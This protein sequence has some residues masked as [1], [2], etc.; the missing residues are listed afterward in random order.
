[1][2]VRTDERA[3]PAAA[4][5]APP[6]R[7][8]WW[9]AAW[10]LVG[11][12]ALAT[13]SSAD[14]LPFYDYYLWLFQGHVVGTLLFGAAGTP[15][16]GQA[17]ALSPVPVPNL[18]APVAIGL[19]NAWLPVETAGRVVVALTV[20]GFAAGFA[21]LARTVQG[22]PTWVEFAGVPWAFGFFLAKGY[23]SYLDGLALAFVVVALLHRATSRPDGPGAPTYGV[24]AVL[25]AALYL[26]HLLAW[27]IGV[28]AVVAHAVL[29][30]RRGRS[31]Q[32]RLLV[33]TQLPGAVMLGWY[34]AAERGG[35]GTAFYTSWT[36][37]AIALLE[38]AL[39]FLRLDPFPPPF[40]VFWANLAV[41]L[42][43]A[44][45]VVRQTR[46]AAA[47][48]ALAARPV[49]WLACALAAVALL[50]PI[51]ELND[52]IKPDER[53]VLP[54]VL[55]ALAGLP[56]RRLRL[57]TAGV[58]LGLVGVVLA[59]HT[60]EYAAAARPIRQVE[61]ATDA[62]VPPGSRVLQLAIPSRTGCAPASG[63]AIG[64]PTLKWFGVDHV[65]D[66]GGAVVA[67]D[68]TSIVSARPDAGPPDLTALTPTSPA[69]AATVALTSSPPVPYVLLVACAA[70]LDTTTGLLAPT[71]SPVTRGADYAILTRRSG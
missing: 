34:T 71:Y 16:L 56:A 18:A 6:R 3:A 9:P 40:P 25:G 4:P 54:A 66:T 43:V 67:L 12:A 27:S 65:M 21:F 68:E 22:R 47:R 13:L 58:V 28:L 41:G 38:P 57:P 15:G 59:L 5:T 31:G 19:L 52:L 36:D 32:G 17:Y 33:A 30:H 26:A 8:P 63:V 42:V 7:I 35:S 1:M 46:W 70:D 62:A 60:V 61:A 24:L 50:L 39:F 49:L 48:A 55:F 69:E 44:G 37:K 53:F 29:L 45:L 20:V 64:V 11:A 2:P 23:L 51:A 10:L 14:V